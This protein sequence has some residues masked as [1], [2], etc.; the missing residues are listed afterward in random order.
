MSLL[1]G[2]DGRFVE[3][4]LGLPRRESVSHWL[5]YLQEGVSYSEF[6]GSCI[7]PMHLI[8]DTPLARKVIQVFE[9]ESAEREETLQAM[10]A[11]LKLARCF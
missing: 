4:T 3:K 11:I 2:S 5:A 9:L 8:E 1:K 10:A 6:E 7:M